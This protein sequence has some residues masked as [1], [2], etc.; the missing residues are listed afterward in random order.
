MRRPRTCN[1]NGGRKI[2]QRHTPQNRRCFVFDIVEWEAKINPHTP[3]IRPKT[4]SANREQPRALFGSGGFGGGSVAGAARRMDSRRGVLRPSKAL[5]PLAAYPR[6][7]VIDP[8][9]HRS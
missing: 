8:P 1:R 6:L 2:K 7:G 5:L 3:T 4:T 9:E